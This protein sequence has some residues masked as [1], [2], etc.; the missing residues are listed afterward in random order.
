MTPTYLTILGRHVGLQC[1]SSPL[2]IVLVRRNDVQ[3]IK[4]DVVAILV[5]LDC[6]TQ[7]VDSL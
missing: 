7:C 5:V 3:M 1:L 2:Y 6:S 4:D